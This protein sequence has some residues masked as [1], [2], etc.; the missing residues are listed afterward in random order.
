M[1]LDITKTSSNNNNLVKGKFALKNLRWK[2]QLYKFA[3][4][5]KVTVYLKRSL[6]SKWCSVSGLNCRYLNPYFRLKPRAGYQI[7]VR[8]LKLN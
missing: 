4:A 2:C 8:I 5:V 6:V 3:S 7:T 1:I